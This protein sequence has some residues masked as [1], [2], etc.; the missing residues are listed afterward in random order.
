M[1]INKKIIIPSILL[2]FVVIIN[3]I[4]YKYWIEFGEL[5]NIFFPCNMDGYI[6]FPCY[7]VYAIYL[8]LIFL[9]IWILLL[10][11]ITYILVN[12]KNNIQKTKLQEFILIIL[13]SVWIWFIFFVIFSL[14]MHIVVN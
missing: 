3:S 2:I 1:Q 12:Q 6:S 14:Y 4:I 13:Y 10:G 8:F 5:I 9:I 11:K 7:W